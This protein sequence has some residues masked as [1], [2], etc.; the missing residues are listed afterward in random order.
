MTQAMMT[1]MMLGNKFQIEINADRPQT[2]L[3]TSLNLLRLVETV[4]TQPADLVDLGT[5]SPLC[6]RLLSQSLLALTV[7]FPR[8]HTELKLS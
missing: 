3:M 4:Q 1:M 5:T 7:D 2:S 6:H 8:P